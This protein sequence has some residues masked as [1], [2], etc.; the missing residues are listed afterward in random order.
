MTV[1]DASSGQNDDNPLTGNSS[2]GEDDG[3]LALGIVEDRYVLENAGQSLL[4]LCTS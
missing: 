3:G 4:C 1:A 2:V